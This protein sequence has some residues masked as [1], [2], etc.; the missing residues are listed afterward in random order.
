MDWLVIPE[1]AAQNVQYHGYQ[2]GTTAG[3]VAWSTMMKDFPQLEIPDNPWDVC[4]WKKS[5]TGARQQLL[6]AA[7]T[8]VKAG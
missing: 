1:H 4:A 2:N 8:K 3:D 7:W 6:N 5:P